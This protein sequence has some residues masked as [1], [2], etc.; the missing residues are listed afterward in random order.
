MN[1]PSKPFQFQCIVDTPHAICYRPT[2][3]IT[4]IKI[5]E[6]LFPTLHQ[7]AEQGQQSNHII[8]KK[9]IMM[10]LY[11]TLVRPHFGLLGHQG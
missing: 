8:K 11:K 10:N 2:N 3:L 6:L 9:G 1:I 7:I 5:G 4:T